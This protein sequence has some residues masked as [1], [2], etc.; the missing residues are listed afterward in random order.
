MK[1]SAYIIIIILLVVVIFQGLFIY[2]TDCECECDTF[3]TAAFIATL[4][5][6]YP[7]TMYV[8]VHDTVYKNI[9]HVKTIEIEVPKDIDSLEV[10]KAY[11][12]SY[13]VTDTIL[14]DTNGLIVVD[15]SV[16]MNKIQKRTIKPMKLF[17]SYKVVTVEKKQEPKNSFYLGFGVNGNYNRLG[18]S[19]NMM[20]CHKNG[21]AY[22][23]GYD[24]LNK[25]ININIYW[26][27]KF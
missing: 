18:A 22:S 8:P 17:P 1:K 9:N 14:N 6:V 12:T 3:D 15:D 23:L 13:I 27:I 4:P 2:N 7:D 20:L 10:A 5:I 19:A 25:E 26:K 21:T 16:S 24:F 11:F